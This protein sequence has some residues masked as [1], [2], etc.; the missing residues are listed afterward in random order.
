LGEHCLCAKENVA[1]KIAELIRFYNS[2]SCQ[3]VLGMGAVVFGKIGQKSVT[4]RNLCVCAVTLELLIYLVKKITIKFPLPDAAKLIEGIVDHHN[5]I[6][7]KLKAIL[8]TRIH[9]CLPEV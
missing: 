2:Q 4:S 9:N 6:I 7:K 3:L 5:E 8:Q 1:H